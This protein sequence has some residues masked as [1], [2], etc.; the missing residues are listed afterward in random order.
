MTNNLYMTPGPTEIPLSVL[1]AMIKGAVSPG[2]PEFLVAMDD[3][4]RL[5]EELFCTENWVL[6]FPGSGRV[7]IESAFLSVLEEGDKV[8]VPVNGVFS[9]WLG[10][11]VERLG[12]EPV[13]VD[14]DWRRAV[15]PSRIGEVLDEVPDIKV[16]SLVHNETSTGVV[17]P[18]K[19]IGDVVRDHEALF[20]V[21]SVSSLGGDRVDTDAWGIDLNCTGSYKCINCVPGLSIVSVSDK[22]WNVM[23][24]RERPARSYGFDLYRWLELWIPPER[25]GKYIWGYR[26]HPTEPAPHLTFALREAVRLLLEEG[27]EARFR[28]NR[29]AGEAVRAG[30]KAMGLEL[31]PLDEA[32]ASNTVTGIVAPEGIGSGKILGAMRDDHGVIIG[33]GLEETHEKVLR[34]AHMGFTSEEMYIQKTILSLEESLKKVGFDLQASG[35]S[36]VRDVFEK[37]KG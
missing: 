35:L 31:Y 24:R 4:E 28:K 25:G 11:I 15:D 1:Q 9:K 6:F 27:L 13:R 23:S 8:L 19:E 7:T 3:T 30:V 33:G 21:D 2:D 36:A 20:F 5:L 32:H 12:A 18:V 29:V 26:R 10:V 14:F 37:A 17:N 34:I 16:V 22:A